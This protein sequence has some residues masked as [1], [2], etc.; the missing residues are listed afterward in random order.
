MAEARSEGKEAAAK[1]AQDPSSPFFIHP[2]ENPAMVLMTP[3]LSDGNYYTW[4]T[5]MRMCLEMKNKD[6]FID[7]TIPQPDFDDPIFPYWK[8]CNTLVLG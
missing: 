2:N 7:G 8:R 3:V 5:S 6:S 1:M 4:S